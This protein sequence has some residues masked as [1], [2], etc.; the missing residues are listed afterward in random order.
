MHNNQ[1]QLIHLIKYKATIKTGPVISKSKSNPK[2]Q[3]QTY[4]TNVCCQPSPKKV[5]RLSPV[6]KDRKE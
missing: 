1:K 5:K 4:F 2:K 3:I 6:Q